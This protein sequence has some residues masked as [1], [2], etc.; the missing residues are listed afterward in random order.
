LD[1]KH[2]SDV[3]TPVTPDNLLAFHRKL[4]APKYDGHDKH[5]P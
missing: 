1:P 2:L 3:A 4:I 5:G